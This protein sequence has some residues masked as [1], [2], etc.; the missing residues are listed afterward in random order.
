MP[1]KEGWGSDSDYGKQGKADMDNNHYKSEE[2]EEVSEA[3]EDDY[4]RQMVELAKKYDL[5][6]KNLQYRLA[7]IALT[8]GISMEGFSYQ[9]TI[10]FTANG[11]IVHYDI[12]NMTEVNS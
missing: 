3:E 9:D 4:D 12:R 1:K 8:Y 11:K 2:D 6:V 7:K 5:D 10:T